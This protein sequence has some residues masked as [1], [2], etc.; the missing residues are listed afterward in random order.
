MKILRCF[1]QFSSKVPSKPCPT[2]KCHKAVPEN[3]LEPEVWNHKFEKLSQ[4]RP[5]AF[6][7][8]NLITNK[9]IGKSSRCIYKNPEYFSYH[10]YSYNNLEEDLNCKRC[11]PQPSPYWRV[12][13]CNTDTRRVP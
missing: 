11:K 10:P 6:V 1:R 2:P 8:C 5:R 4:V 13:F 3:Y 12:L 7:Q 9:C